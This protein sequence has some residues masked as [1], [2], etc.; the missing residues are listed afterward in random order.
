[1]IH[2]DLEF[3]ASIATDRAE[4]TAS[5]FVDAIAWLGEM[6]EAAR[7]DDM[8]APPHGLGA[9][10]SLLAEKAAADSG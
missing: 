7:E 2:T 1:M 6:L 4:I 5:R 8:A 3:A 9:L 10:L